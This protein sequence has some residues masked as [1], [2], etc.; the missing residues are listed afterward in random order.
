M[1]P[2]NKYGALQHCTTLHTTTL[3]HIPHYTTYHYT[4]PHTTTLHHI[5]LQPTLSHSVYHIPLHCTT[6]HYTAKHTTTPHTTVPLHCNTYHYTPYTPYHCTATHTT[7][8]YH[9]PLHSQ[10]IS[11]T[12][13]TNHSHTS[14]HTYHYHTTTCNRLH[15]TVFY[16][17]LK[18][19]IHFFQKIWGHNFILCKKM[20]PQ[21]TKRIIYFYVKVGWYIFFCQNSGHNLWTKNKVGSLISDIDFWQKMG[22]VN[23]PCIDRY[24]W[25]FI[26]YT[27]YFVS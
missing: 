8:L 23:F 14:L 12:H 19:V 11:P 18:W 6:Y 16:I 27:Y 10:Q 26:I 13:F 2:Y 4:T 5:P 24:H 1:Q 25:V 17:F 3:H 7:T 20:I 21:K 22:V 15:C 9:I